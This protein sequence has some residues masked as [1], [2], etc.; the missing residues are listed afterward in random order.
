MIK[1]T[2]GE[3]RDLERQVWHYQAAF[4]EHDCR[5]MSSM[6]LVM[7]WLE[8]LLLDSHETNLPR[9]VQGVQHIAFHGSA[10]CEI[11][12]QGCPSQYNPHA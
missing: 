5:M 2:I 11:P 4:W 8:V 3:T 10:T 7:G 12:A 1:D 9:G 6:L